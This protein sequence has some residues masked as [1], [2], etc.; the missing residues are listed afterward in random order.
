MFNTVLSNHMGCAAIPQTR[1][2][3]GWKEGGT[4]LGYH[5]VTQSGVAGNEMLPRVRQDGPLRLK[6]RQEHKEVERM[7]WCGQVWAE[8]PNTCGGEGRLLITD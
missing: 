3:H 6:D 1:G 2:K 5:S 8:S 4:G 7:V